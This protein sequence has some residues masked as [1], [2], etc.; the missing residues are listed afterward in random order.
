MEEIV[1]LVK[2]QMDLKG[3]KKYRIRKDTGLSWKQLEDFFK[4]KDLY[5]R[6]VRA[7]LLSVGIKR[8]R[9]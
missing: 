3:I 7:V 2:E 6:N 8:I 5:W 1:K 9:L 4:G